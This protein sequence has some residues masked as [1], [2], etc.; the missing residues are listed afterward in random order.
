ME[1][2]RHEH[3]ELAVRAGPAWRRSEPTRNLTIERHREQDANGNVACSMQAAI[4]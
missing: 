3:R 1:I 4:S 2:L